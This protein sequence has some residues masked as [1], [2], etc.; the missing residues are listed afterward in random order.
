MSARCVG[1]P[2]GGACRHRVA[3]E[4]QRCPSCWAKV[5]VAPDGARIAALNVAAVPDDIAGKLS[6]DPCDGVRFALATLPVHPDVLDRLTGDVSPMVRRA[7]AGN[8]D[9]EGHSAFHL[10]VSE[11]ELTLTVLAANPALPGEA[12][13]AL[14]EHPSPAVRAALL[15]SRTARRP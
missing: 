13:D 11:D 15:H 7:V 4:N 1:V 3:G 2:G 12:R 14:E 9:L 10:L 6:N 5:L 8:P